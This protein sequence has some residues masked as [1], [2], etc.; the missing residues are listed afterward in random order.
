[1]AQKKN[2]VG[3]IGILVLWTNREKLY[4]KRTCFSDKLLTKHYYMTFSKTHLLNHQSMTQP[5]C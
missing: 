4:Y 1:M 5:D 2:E 3:N